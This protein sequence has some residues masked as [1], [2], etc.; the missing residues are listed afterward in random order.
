[1]KQRKV[2]RIERRRPLVDVN[3][4]SDGG[5]RPSIARRGR[6]CLSFLTPGALV[7]VALAAHA[8]GLH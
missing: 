8:L 1:M 4:I 7:G 2:E 5:P 3:L 6:G